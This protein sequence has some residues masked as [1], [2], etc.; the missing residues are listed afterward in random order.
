MTNLEAIRQRH[1]VRHFDGKPINKKHQNILNNIINKINEESNMRFQL[2][3]NEPIAFSGRRA[4]LTHFTGCVNYLAIVGPKNSRLREKAGY[5]GE[6]IVLS[7]QK[8]GIMSCWV[9]KTFDKVKNAYMVA[10]GEKLVLVIALGY[11]SYKGKKHDSKPFD[12]VVINK[13]DKEL[14]TWFKNGVECALLAPTGINQQGFKFQLLS[15]N[16]VKVKNRSFCRDVD[17]GIVKYHFE[18]GAGD[19]KFEWVK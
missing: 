7:A 15:N 14:P 1:A 19:A 3:I 6:K 12:K 8:L 18:V 5:Y 13:D 2:V 9:A 17:L 16:R 4:A 10:K 11:A